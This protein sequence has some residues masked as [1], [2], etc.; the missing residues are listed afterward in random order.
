MQ[1][2]KEVLISSVN[3]SAGFAKSQNTTERSFASWSSHQKESR[4]ELTRGGL[5]KG[6]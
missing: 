3:T 2:E 4:L 5:L 6:A 1:G